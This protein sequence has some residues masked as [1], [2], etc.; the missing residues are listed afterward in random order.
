MG[1]FEFCGKKFIYSILVLSMG[2]PMIFFSI[3]VYQILRML[4]FENSIIGLI[5]AEIGGGHVIFILLFVSFF[6]SIPNE[7]EE[8]AVIDGANS[9]NIFFENNVSAFKTYYWN[10]SYNT[11]NMD[12]ELLFIPVNSI[13]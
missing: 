2:M 6:R 7:I 3:P 13:N 1:R 12:M 4:N 9:Y 10:S 11:V 5:L 8:A